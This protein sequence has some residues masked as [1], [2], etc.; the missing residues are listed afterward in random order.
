MTSGDDSAEN[1]ADE[2][3]VIDVPP[4]DVPSIG[5]L[6]PTAFSIQENREKW[7][8]RFALILMVLLSL[9]ATGFVAVSVALVRPFSTQ[10]LSLLISGIFGPVIGLVG[11]VVGFY[12][13]QVSAEEKDESGGSGAATPRS[14]R[15][16]L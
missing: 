8:G 5:Q 6:T 16:R 3:V 9:L 12:Y 7:R 1:A 11:T 2:P 14:R 15:R 10:T 13:G 4:I